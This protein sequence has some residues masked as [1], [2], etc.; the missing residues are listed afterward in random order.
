MTEPL[1]GP[2]DREGSQPVRQ[3]LLFA[4][5]FLWVLATSDPRDLSAPKPS[6]CRVYRFIH[7]HRLGIA[8]PAR[9]DARPPCQGPAIPTTVGLA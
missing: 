5:L 7:T 9:E 3:S 6:T 2:P 1:P 8:S 4:A